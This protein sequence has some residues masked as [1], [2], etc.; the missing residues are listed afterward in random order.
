MREFA[1]ENARELV[2]TLWKSD[3]CSDD[4]FV[5]LAE[6]CCFLEALES[7]ILLFKPKAITE[8]EKV[9]GCNLE[10]ITDSTFVSWESVDIIEISR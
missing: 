1:I 8:G 6:E 2:I 7:G 10:D 5:I 4:S 3:L 9:T